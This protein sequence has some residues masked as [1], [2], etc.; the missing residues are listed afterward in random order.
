MVLF[1]F[2][3]II[4]NIQEISKQ[5]GISKDM[6]RFYEKKGLIH[7]TRHENN[8]RSYTVHDIHLLILIKQYNS[9]GIPLSSIQSLLLDQ[10]YQNTT[11]EFSKQIEQLKLDAEWAYARYKNAKDL[12]N[13]INTYKS[14]NNYDTGIRKDL[15]YLNN[16]NIA[17]K[18]ITYVNSG[19]ARAV[20]HI[21]QDTL[22]QSSYPTDTGLLF[23]ENHPNDNYTYQHIPEHMFY[24]TIVEVPSNQIISMTKLQELIQEMHTRGYQECGDIFIYQTLVTG[25]ACETDIICVEFVVKQIK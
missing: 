19:I 25:N 5:T 9:L 7:P 11:K 2:S 20:Y 23:T 3:Q 1:I 17:E 24:R 14:P 6:I 18:S 13:I 21:P 16:Q 12:L 8:Y 4:M 10:D 15:Y 22:Q